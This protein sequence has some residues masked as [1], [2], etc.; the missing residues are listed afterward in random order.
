[1]KLIKITDKDDEKIFWYFTTMANA[2]KYVGISRALFEYNLYNKKQ[3]KGWIL[4][5]VNMY[6]GIFRYINPERKYGD[7]NY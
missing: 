2:A 3:T 1:M 4:E 5:E 7:Y 6:D